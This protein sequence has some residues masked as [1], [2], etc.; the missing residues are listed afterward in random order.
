[1]LCF[2]IRET[3][4]Y[5]DFLAF[6]RDLKKEIMRI[7]ISSSTLRSLSLCLC[8]I[9]TMYLKFLD[10]R[11][12]FEQYDLDGNNELSPREFG[13]FLVSHVNQ[14]RRSLSSCYGE[15]LGSDDVDAYAER[16]WQVGRARR[17][18]ARDEGTRSRD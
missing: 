12:Y 7:Q 6:R 11:E 9:C 10:D 17:G 8:M 3:L 1:M 18:A 4:S 14:V 2:A 13:M 5:E 15:R 16:D